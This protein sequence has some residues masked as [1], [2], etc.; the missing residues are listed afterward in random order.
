VKHLKANHN[1]NFLQRLQ[2][3]VQANE[4]KKGKLH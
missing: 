2:Q 1:L 4:H 3:G